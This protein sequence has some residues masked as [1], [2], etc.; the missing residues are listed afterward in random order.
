MRPISATWPSRTPTSARTRGLRVP[1]I[2]M[3][4]LIT[5]SYV[6][7]G[8]PSNRCSNPTTAPRRGLWLLDADRPHVDAALAVVERQCH[9]GAHRLAAGRPRVPRRHRPGADV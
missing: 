2:S 5:T 4:P 8:P 3:P 9:E 7:M 6:A 1:S